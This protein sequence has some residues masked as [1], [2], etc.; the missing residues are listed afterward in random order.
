MILI[1]TVNS[2]IGYIDIKYRF[3]CTNL[4]NCGEAYKGIQPPWRQFNCVVSY[5]NEKYCTSQNWN[6][7]T[8]SPQPSN[9]T[10]FFWT[11][12]LWISAK[13]RTAWFLIDKCVFFIF[14]IE[15]CTNEIGPPTHEFVA[16]RVSRSATSRTNRCLQTSAPPFIV[17]TAVGKTQLYANT[18]HRPGCSNWYN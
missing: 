4:W 1:A 5:R 11:S 16:A 9:E 10:S 8:R 3:R 17:R 18:P 15:L 12:N 6:Y 14:L 2:G 7:A 13:K